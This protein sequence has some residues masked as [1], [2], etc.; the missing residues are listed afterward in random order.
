MRNKKART[1]SEDGGSGH[2][3]RNGVAFRSRKGRG[4]ES[5]GASGEPTSAHTLLSAQ[6]DP[7]QTRPPEHEEDT[8]VLFS[9][10]TLVICQSSKRKHTQGSPA[11]REAGGTWGYELFLVFWVQE[12]P[13]WAPSC[14]LLRVPHATS[15]PAVCSWTA[16]THRPL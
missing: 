1:S 8:F 4:R 14:R 13:A 10:S 7:P 5:P 9:A 11:L 15:L 16:H 6:R 3:P 2:E 12:E